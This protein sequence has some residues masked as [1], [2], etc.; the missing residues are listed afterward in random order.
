M[1]RR[2]LSSTR[3][4]GCA[5]HRS[6][7]VPWQCDEIA[8]SGTSDVVSHESGVCPQGHS[9]RPARRSCECFLG[10]HVEAIGRSLAHALL[11]RALGL[12]RAVPRSRSPSDVYAQVRDLALVKDLSD[13]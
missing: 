7:S 13:L 5:P 8:L 12:W 1:V 10:R 2:S 3:E 4:I 9:A 6:M 11:S